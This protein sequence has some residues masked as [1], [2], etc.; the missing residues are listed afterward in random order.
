MKVLIIAFMAMFS[1]AAIADTT[2]Q[3]SF[4]Y[5]GQTEQ[6]SV[7]LSTEK[8]KTVWRTVDVPSTCYRTVMRR[9]CRTER[10]ECRRRCDSHGNCRRVCTPSRRVCSTVPTRVPYSCIRQERRAFQEHDYFVDTNVVFNFDLSDVESLLAENFTVKT[11][12]ETSNISVQGSKSVAIFIT[13]ESR[14]ENMTNGTKFI[15]LQYSLKLIPA[16]NINGVLASGIQNVDLNN[17]VLT[18]TL[19]DNFNTKDFFQNVK[20]YQSRRLRKDILLLDKN[21]T[22]DDFIIETKNGRSMLSVDLNR[23]GV[24][25]PFRTR[26]IISVGY[27]QLGY[28][29]LNE[30]DIKLEANANWILNN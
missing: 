17:G 10:P 13:D 23:L 29:L 27:N 2:E 1:I 6:M 7:N 26:V 19:G 12:G 21:L 4:L 25:V 9:V 22:E 14:S 16:E 20:V 8:T 18:Y 24:N 3:R 5:Q 30:E 15:D 28:K 11:S